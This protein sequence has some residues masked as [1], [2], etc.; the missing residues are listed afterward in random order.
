[1]GWQAYRNAKSAQIWRFFPPDF[2]SFR[3]VL[4]EGRA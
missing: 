2:A 1:L 4:H 3:R